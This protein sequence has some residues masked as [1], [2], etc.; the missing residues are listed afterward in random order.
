MAIGQVSSK[1]SVKAVG[2]EQVRSIED[3]MR[4]LE[5]LAPSG[6]PS[7]KMKGT[8]QAR[9][10]EF[11]GSGGKITMD[12]VETMLAAEHKVLLAIARADANESGRPAPTDKELSQKIAKALQQAADNHYAWLKPGNEV[13]TNPEAKP[14]GL[15][16]TDKYMRG[17][18]AQTGK[19][20]PWVPG[21]GGDAWAV[22][23]PDG[24]VG[25]YWLGEMTPTKLPKTAKPD[26]FV[27]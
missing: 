9:R 1:G 4:S 3:Y 10:K 21:H 2:P 26:V 20:H 27:G 17:R 24:K 23:H 13:R 11:F 18:Q 15:L 12:E 19:L 14:V 25:V 7:A 5:L 6:L 22:Q 8:F 16:V